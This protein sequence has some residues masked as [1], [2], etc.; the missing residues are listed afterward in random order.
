MGTTGSKGKYFVRNFNFRPF[1]ENG[2]KEYYSTRGDGQKTKKTFSGYDLLYFRF[3]FRRLCLLGQ[4]MITVQKD[5]CMI[6]LHITWFTNKKSL[7]GRGRANFSDGGVLIAV[8][9]KGEWR[10]I[11][12]QNSWDLEGRWLVDSRK[13]QW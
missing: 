13:G 1:W 7:G 10:D 3:L 8:R 4:F 2:S 11:G 9:W 5:L 12:V 6:S